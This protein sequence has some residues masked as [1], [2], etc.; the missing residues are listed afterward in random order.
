MSGLTDPGASADPADGPV[1]PA[2]ALP[3]QAL[4]VDAS[5]LAGGVDAEVHPG[6]LV[7]EMR[8][9]LAG[10]PD[11]WVALEASHA[12]IQLVLQSMPQI[13]WI[14][15]PDGWHTFFNRQWLDFTGLTL[16]ESLGLG[17]NPPFHPDDRDRA[18]ARWEQATSTGEP[19]EIEYR[20]RRADGVYH[21]M[22]GRAMPLRDAGG[23]IVKWF[24]TCTDIEELKQAQVQI[25]AQ[26]RL[27]D[28]A[29]DAIFVEDS[30]RRIVY[31][32]H[33]AERISGW[34]AEKA[35]GRTLDE[36]ICPDRRQ[37]DSAL[38]VL[39]KRGEW[40]GELSFVDVTGKTR[41]TE[42]RMTVLRDADGGPN[43]VL[44]VNTDVT[45]R[46]VTEAK[47]LQVL[48]RSLLTQPAPPPS[49]DLAVRYL[50][51]VATAQVGGDWHDAHDNGLGSTLISVGDVAGH[52][53][54]SAA[55]MAQI[56]NVL[57]GLAVDSDDS[58]AVLLTRLDRAMHRFGLD[59]LASAVLGRIDQSADHR[60]R[61]MVQLRWS[62]AGHLPPLLRLPDGRVLTL[63]DDSDPM[64][65]ISPD[66]DR[67]E[68]ITQM[69][70]GSTLL[71]YTD[72]LVERRGESLT[73]GLRRL[74]DA[75]AVHGALGVEELADAVVQT[76]I[77]QAPDDDVAL[78]IVRP[79]PAS[80]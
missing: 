27:L 11:A 9:E 19:Y 3:S 16:E 5:V 12:E 62:S 50:P 75:L 20:L 47:F 49:L 34:S 17:W 40:S 15:R 45:E 70:Y 24:G 60:R 6:A 80:K 78:L 58:P 4:P 1:L 39:L 72:G 23:T 51:A 43:G 63:A 74:A 54:N 64:L 56:R 13:V 8:R 44:A 71:L 69:P 61:G 31:W 29:Q 35:V 55:A 67:V 37:I 77:P 25:E 2:L 26:A 79:Q 30:E 68:R 59:T 76:M 7:Q 66:I 46:R 41:V 22:L 42:S 10:V 57:R 48:Q 18:A 14:T 73:I 65:G 38:A 53:S 33:G 32:N 36:L 52:E 21:W 28:L